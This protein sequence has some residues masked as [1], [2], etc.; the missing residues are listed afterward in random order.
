MNADQSMALWN[1]YWL[2]EAGVVVC[3]KCLQGQRLSEGD[4]PFVH[5]DGCVN[6]GD[7]G[8]SPWVELHN[9]LD[10]ARG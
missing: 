7:G 4:Q 2:L 8:S 10:S 9:V 1:S 5:K 3:R 6:A